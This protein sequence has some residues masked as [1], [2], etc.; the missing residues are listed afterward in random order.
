MK[1]IIILISLI[2]LVSICNAQELKEESLTLEVFQ[3]IDNNELSSNCLARDSHF[4]VCR[5]IS[6]ST[7]E[8]GK[9]YKNMGNTRMYF[10][11]G[12]DISGT[13]IFIGIWKYESKNGNENT[14]PVYM[15][16]DNFYSYWDNT[17]VI[18]ENKERFIDM[19]KI[20]VDYCVIEDN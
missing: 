7:K 16:K 6:F 18:E 12:Q 19:L 9:Y 4:N 14:V 3:V 13:Y 11:D 17:C 1:K 8:L 15:K 10:Y 20:F 5:V 2:S